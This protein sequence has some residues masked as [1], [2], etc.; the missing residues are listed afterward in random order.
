M[1][2]DAGVPHTDGHA[3]TRSQPVAQTQR[4]RNGVVAGAPTQMLGGGYGAVARTAAMAQTLQM[5]AA[6]APLERSMPTLASP[7]SNGP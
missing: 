3:V 4:P 1:A 5:S 6:V 7:C 2:C